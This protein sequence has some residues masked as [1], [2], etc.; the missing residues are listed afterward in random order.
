MKY[1]AMCLCLVSSC[2]VAQ[3]RI[4]QTDSVGNKQYH[5]PQYVVKDNKVYQTDSVGNVKYHKPQLVII[6]TKGKS[7][8]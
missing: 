3:Q 8:K 2:V 1:L 7:S 5:K 6:Q 4:V